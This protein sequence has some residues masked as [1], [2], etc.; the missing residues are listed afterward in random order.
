MAAIV[1]SQAYADLLEAAL[2][3]QEIEDV[4][5]LLAAG[6]DCTACLGELAPAPTR[7]LALIIER[8]GDGRAFVE[9]A[10]AIRRP[11]V[12]L[13]PSRETAG[14][15]PEESPAAIGAALRKAGAI[16]AATLEELADAVACLAANADKLPRVPEATLMAPE[17]LRPWLLAAGQAE[18]LSLVGG[19]A[20]LLMAAPE[21]G[22]SV[23]EPRFG[24]GSPKVAPPLGGIIVVQAASAPSILAEGLAS[25]AAT[26]P[27]TAC[28]ADAVQ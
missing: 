6:D 18:G 13:A 1:P 5:I 8:F 20:A 25:V 24:A 3:Q 28:F 9:A 21:A 23:A 10:Q 22:A 17:P 27:V 12:V 2:L 11:L 26:L 16:R 15:E 7:A 19:D 4:R 14:G